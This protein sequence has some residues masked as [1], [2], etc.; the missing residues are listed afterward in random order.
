MELEEEQEAKI[1]LRIAGSESKS[2]TFLK[3]TAY[4]IKGYDDNGE[5][6]V[7]RRFSEFH[8]MRTALCKRW[9][10]CFIPSIP[11]KNF[12]G[13]NDKEEIVKRERYLTDF[14]YKLTKLPHLYL[15]E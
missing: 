12:M 7:S 11:E 9:P 2:T 5:I 13:K 14:L 15:S 6:N 4:V 8:A 3:Y 10:G 1:K